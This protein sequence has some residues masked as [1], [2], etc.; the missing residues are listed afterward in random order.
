MNSNIINL[1]IKINHQQIADLKARRDA[2][3]DAFLSKPGD[4][5]WQRVHEILDALSCQL[6]ALGEEQEALEA[7]DLTQEGWQWQHFHQR[8]D[9]IPADILT[10]G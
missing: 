4:A 2:V 9:E 7:G 10:G 6:L 1:R 5:G 3:A 8:R